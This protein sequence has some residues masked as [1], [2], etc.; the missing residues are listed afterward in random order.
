MHGPAASA[1]SVMLFGLAG[2]LLIGSALS[3]AKLARDPER[4]DE[5]PVIPV[6]AFRQAAALTA[7]AFVMLGLASCWLAL[8]AL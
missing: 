6:R 8:T 4:L 1:L 5:M 2:L 3:W 7:M